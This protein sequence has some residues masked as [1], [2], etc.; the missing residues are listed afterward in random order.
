MRKHV[1]ACL[2]STGGPLSTLDSSSSHASLKREQLEP[3]QS[4]LRW[5]AGAQAGPR[6]GA[7]S[8]SAGSSTPRSRSSAAGSGFCGADTLARYHSSSITAYPF[9]RCFDI[10]GHSPVES[11]SERLKVRSPY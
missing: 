8:P 10:A 7:S 6:L 1:V 11:V 3:P 5:C 9:S 4:N 2:Q